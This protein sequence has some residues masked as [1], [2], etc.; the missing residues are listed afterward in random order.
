MCPLL[1]IALFIIKSRHQSVFGA[2]KQKLNFR[3]LIQLSETLHVKC[4][5]F[6]RV[7]DPKCSEIVFHLLYA[8]L[9]Q[10]EGKNVLILLQHFGVCLKLL[11][12]GEF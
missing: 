9:V 8:M 7:K 3:L 5:Q 4:S 12:E 11:Y 6:L 2:Y 10:F 1:K